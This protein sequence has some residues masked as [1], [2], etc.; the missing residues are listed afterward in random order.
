MT[1]TTHA[2]RF[3]LDHRGR[4]GR[5]LHRHHSE[6]RQRPHDRAQL[7]KW[8]L[9]A[10]IGLAMLSYSIWN[11]YTWYPRMRR[12]AARRRRGRERAERPRDIPAVELSFP[13]CIAFHR[14]GPG[15]SGPFGFGPADL[16]R[17]RRGHSTMVARTA[18]PQAFDCAKGARADLMDGA[19]LFGRRNAEGYRVAYQAADDPLVAAACGGG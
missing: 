9:P 12:C 13:E 2:D 14:G 17:E 7:P 10:G 16:R 19:T 1:E 11:E 4:C 15:D 18:H 6:P 8:V 5:C 3:H